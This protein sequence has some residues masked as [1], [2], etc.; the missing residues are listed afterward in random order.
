L[1]FLKAFAR[2]RQLRR[3]QRIFFVRELAQKGLLLFYLRAQQ[4][5]LDGCQLSR[6]PSRT[7]TATTAA[8]AA[9]AA[10]AGCR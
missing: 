4:H 8:A 1:D 7:A 6:F 3:R 5:Q 9:A 2:R 10:A